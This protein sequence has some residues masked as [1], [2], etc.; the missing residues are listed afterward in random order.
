MRQLFRSGVL[1]LGLLVFFPAWVI[2]GEEAIL[3]ALEDVR[4]GVD[5]G[6]PYHKLVEVMETA[7]VEVDTLEKGVG[8]ACFRAAVRRCYDWYALGLRSWASLRD[9]EKERDKYARQAE[10]GE[11]HFKDISL[12]MAE[13]YDKLVRHAQD[14]LPSKW[15]H[16]NAELEKAHACLEPRCPRRR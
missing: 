10:Y 16:G 11:H 7:R 12:K 2:S 5:A 8:N 9:N 1:T 4:A 6:V 13:N 15:A 3:K 14:A